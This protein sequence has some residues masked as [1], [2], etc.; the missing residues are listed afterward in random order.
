M[1]QL[2]A[3]G[4]LGQQIPVP[5]QASRPPHHHSLLPSIPL[6]SSRHTLTT[7]P[8]AQIL[9][10]HWC[11]RIYQAWWPRILTASPV[12]QHRLMSTAQSPRTLI[13]LLSIIPWV[14]LPIH[15]RRIRHTSRARQRTVITRKMCCTGTTANP[16]PIHEMT[17]GM[18][19]L[20]TTPSATLTTIHNRMF[21]YLPSTTCITRS[22]HIPTRHPLHPTTS[23]TFP[24][25]V[26]PS[27]ISHN[28]RLIRILLLP[29]LAHLPQRQ[30]VL[31]L[32]VRL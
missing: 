21:H 2:Q 23:P 32:R 16:P 6:H 29:S 13:F 1:A 24:Q 4:A 17:F 8:L 15:P 20:K 3:K 5:I 10:L 22:Q 11:R 12:A 9:H 14:V 7:L 25:H 26:I 18:K 19:K 30:F 31:A 27:Q 28:L